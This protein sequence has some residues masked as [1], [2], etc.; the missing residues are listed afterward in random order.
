MLN[1]LLNHNKSLEKFTKIV[2]PKRNVSLVLIEYLHQ[3][4]LFCL[5][6][7]ISN[8]FENTQMLTLPIVESGVSELVCECFCMFVVGR[9]SQKQ[10]LVKCLDQQV[11]LRMFY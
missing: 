10:G 3:K 5:C 1:I 9:I 2:A 11:V 7:S 8:T 4:N 6:V